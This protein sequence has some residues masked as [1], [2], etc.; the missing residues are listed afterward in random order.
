MP[1]FYPPIDFEAEKASGDEINYAEIAVLEALDKGLDDKWHVFHR[2]HWREVSPQGEK[3]GEA[4]AVIF[5]PVYGILIVEIKG[6]GVRAK[7][8]DWF[9]TNIRTGKEYKLDTSPFVQARSSRFRLFDKLKRTSLGAGFEPN[10]AFTY[11]VWFPDITWTE[12]IPADAPN[13]AFIL[14]SKHLNNPSQHIRNILKQ[15]NPHA[16]PW[17]ERDTNI[18]LRTFAP[19]VNLLVPLGVNLGRIRTRIFAMT[20]SQLRAYKALRQQKRLLIEGCAGSGKTLI[21]ASLA[22]EHLSAGKR[23]LFTCYNKRLAHVVENDFEGTSGIDVVNFHELVKKYCDESGTKYAV[24][25]GR[26]E[27]ADFF[28]ST[29][30]ELLLDC[31]SKSDKRYD[32]IIVDEA[33]DFQETWWTAVESLGAEGFSFYVFFDRNQAVF[34]NSTSWK[35]PFEADPIVLETN[36]RNTRPIGRFAAKLGRIAEAPDYGVNEGPEP[37]LLPY[38]SVDEIPEMLKKLLTELTGKQKILPGNIVVLSPYKLDHERLGLEQFVKEQEK[39]ISTDLED[40]E[41][42]K[43]RIGTIQSFKGLEADVVILC[44]IDGHQPACSPTNLY[45]GATRARSMLYVMHQEKTHIP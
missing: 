25:D 28:K 33:F 5:H 21:A 15:S 13:G 12:A 19:E 11:T 1:L 8:G 2:L 17:T 26:Q 23:V 39:L 27:K 36:V 9:Q 34:T 24:P 40:A 32:T 4:D 30:A 43:V 7:D 3:M 14:D 41:Q 44:G 6:G 31:S 20:D 45:V 10:T 18:L 38:K 42:G 16:K 22:R 35:P 29:C 37:V